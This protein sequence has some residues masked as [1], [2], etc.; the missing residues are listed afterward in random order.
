[1]IVEFASPLMIKHDECDKRF[2]ED[3]HNYLIGICIDAKML[4]KP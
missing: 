3:T 2:G 4:Y 1:M